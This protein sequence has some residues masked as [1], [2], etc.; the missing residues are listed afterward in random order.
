MSKPFED[1]LGN[2]CELRILEFLLPLPDVEFN[3]TELAEEMKV[4]RPTIARIVK[5]YEEWGMLKTRTA[6]NA[7]YYSLNE[8]SPLVKGIVHFNNLIIEKMLGEET[9]NEIHESLTIP[10]KATFPVLQSASQPAW[11]NM[12]IIKSWSVP[13]EDITFSPHQANAVVMKQDRDGGPIQITGTDNE[14]FGIGSRIKAMVT[15]GAS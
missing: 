3:Q 14:G 5:K 4:S 8:E 10:Q 13:V 15:A 1:I 7:K 9:L 11:D 2:N 12:K 6:G